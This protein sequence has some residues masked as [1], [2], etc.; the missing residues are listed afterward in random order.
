MTL[1]DQTLD[2]LRELRAELAD[3]TRAPLVVATRKAIRQ[4]ADLGGGGVVE[5]HVSRA[6]REGQARTLNDDPVVLAVP[7]P[8]GLEAKLV[9]IKSPFGG[10]KRGFNVVNVRRHYKEARRENDGADQRVD[11]DPRRHPGA[12]AA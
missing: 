7:L 10:P 11:E 4:F 1:P 12:G 6:L 3:Q 8:S 9:R 5:N 2:K